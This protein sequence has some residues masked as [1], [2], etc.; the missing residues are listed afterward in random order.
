LVVEDCEGAGDEDGEEDGRGAQPSHSTFL[1]I[2]FPISMESS[3]ARGMGIPGSARSD[4]LSINGP[5]PGFGA[6]INVLLGTQFLPFKERIP[7]RAR[8]RRSRGSIMVLLGKISRGEEILRSTI[9]SEHKA[10]TNSPKLWTA[11]TSQEQQNKHNCKDLNMATRL[12]KT[13]QYPDDNADDALP[14]A[15]DEEGLSIHALPVSA[16]SS[17]FPF[18]QSLR[19]I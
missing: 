12:R 3:R 9:T 14:E 4:L 1:D 2:C 6:A 19:L 8:E 15:L 10:E 17:I 13:F 16:F 7:G 11:S 18:L 5:C